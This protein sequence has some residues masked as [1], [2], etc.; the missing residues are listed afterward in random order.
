MAMKKLLSITALNMTSSAPD[1]LEVIDDVALLASIATGDRVAFNSFLSRH[2]SAVVQFARRYLP[3]QADAEDIAQETFFRVWKKSAS[4]KP[5]GHS[6]RSWVYRIAYNLCIDEIRRRPAIA[7][8]RDDA[9]GVESYNLES[10]SL[11][12]TIEN[13]SD[14]SLLQHSLKSLPERQR[15]AISLCALQGLSNKEAA[16]AMG[17]SVEALESLLSRGRRLLRSR[18]QQDGEITHE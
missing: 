7:P 1:A 15:T 3:N 17:V 11:E 18:V 2:L 14:L 16:T 13:E 5:Q 8:D 4:W 6:P 10:S 9:A 12:T